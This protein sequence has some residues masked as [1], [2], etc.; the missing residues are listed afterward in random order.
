VWCTP[1]PPPTRSSTSRPRRRALLL[2]ALLRPADGAPV[3]LGGALERCQA[4]AE[5]VERWQD[6]FFAALPEEVDLEE[7]ARW[8][9]EA[10]PVA[11]RGRGRATRTR[12]TTAT[13]TCSALAC[14]RRGRRPGR[15]GP[16]GAAG[17]VDR[18]GEMDE[19]DPRR[20]LR[21]T[22]SPSLERELLLLPVRVRLEALVAAADLVDTWSDLLADHEKLLGHLV[23]AHGE[24]VPD[25]RAHEQ[26]A[27]RHAVLHAERGPAH[28]GADCVGRRW[29]TGPGR[30]GRGRS[31]P[32]GTARAPTSRC[33]ARARRRSTSACSTSRPRD[34]HPA[35]GVDLPRLARLPAAGVARDSATASASTGPSTRPRAPLQP[36]EAARR[37]LRPGDRRRLPPRRRGLRVGAR[38]RPGAGPPRLSAVRP[39]LGRRA[40][41]L[42]VGGRPPARAALGPT[43]CSTSCTSRASPP[44]PRRAGALRG[45]YAG[46]GPPAAL[47]T[48]SPRRHRGRAH[49]W[50]TTSCPSRTCCAAG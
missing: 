19:D 11:R 15:G 30:A 16:R 25:A 12:T 29:L 24:P 35:G 2:E 42:P 3:D 47:S 9:A 38:P 7:E 39:A 10:G 36:D 4:G 18:G 23:L 6:A 50:C 37:P 1:S 32:T 45:T 5:L 49:A 44:L 26:L 41:R 34:S 27:D 17:L 20:L 14:A 40:R 28:A 22:W 43:P 48:C 33:S 46:L 13:S 8:A 21:P 31:E